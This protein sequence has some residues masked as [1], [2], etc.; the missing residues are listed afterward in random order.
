[1]GEMRHRPTTETRREA[2]AA[3]LASEDVEAPHIETLLTLIDLHG[4]L[5]SASPKAGI[6][7]R[8]IQQQAKAAARRAWNKTWRALRAAALHVRQACS[9]AAANL[10]RAKVNAHSYQRVRGSAVIARYANPDDRCKGVPVG[11]RSELEVTRLVQFGARYLKEHCDHMPDHY[12]ECLWLE[13]CCERRAT[14]ILHHR[15]ESYG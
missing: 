13:S 9:N 14:S 2:I 1:M 7:A 3:Y 15:G 10:A 4:L 6:T 12:E 11:R 8:A 5:H